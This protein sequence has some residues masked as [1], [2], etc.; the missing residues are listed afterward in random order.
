MIHPQW[1]TVLISLQKFTPPLNNPL[2]FCSPLFF[3]HNPPWSS[4]SLYIFGTFGSQLPIYQVTR[5]D[6]WFQIY[7]YIYVTWR[8][9]PHIIIHRDT[10]P[11][12]NILAPETV[13]VGIRS[14]PFGT[15]S[16]FRGKLAVSFR[17]G[18]FPV[19]LFFFNSFPP[20]KKKL[21]PP[22]STSKDLPQI[23]HQFGSSCHQRP[24]PRGQVTT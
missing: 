24:F 20:P 22:L 15:R 14:F 18:H 17:E 12:T 8:W 19:L 6:P 4:S 1:W 9:G 7:I 13:T 2:I 11:E 23:L 10:L 21:Q 5:L 16:I 3:K